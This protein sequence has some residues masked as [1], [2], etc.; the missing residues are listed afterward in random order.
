MGTSGRILYKPLGGV[1]FR[2]LEGFYFSQP[3]AELNRVLKFLLECLHLK[4]DGEIT[5][6]VITTGMASLIREVAADFEGA[7]VVTVGVEAEAVE[8]E[9]MRAHLAVQQ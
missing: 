9:M 4:R 6:V 7:E 8:W 5:V 3:C 1:C 2:L